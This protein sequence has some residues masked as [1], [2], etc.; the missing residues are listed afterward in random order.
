MKMTWGFVLQSEQAEKLAVYNQ[1][2]KDKMNEFR[3]MMGLPE[4]D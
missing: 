2:E 4:E 3:R 1:K